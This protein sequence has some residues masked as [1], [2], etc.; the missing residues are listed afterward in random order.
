[1]ID[2]DD[3]PANP[4]AAPLIAGQREIIRLLN[5]LIDAQTRREDPAPGL[6]KIF[7]QAYVSNMRLRVKNIVLSCS[8]GNQVFRLLI[9]GAVK[10]RFRIPNNTSTWPF[11]VTVDRGQTVQFVDDATGLPVD[12]AVN[13]VL[14]AWLEAYVDFADSD[15]TKRGQLRDRIT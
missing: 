7:P 9:G 4:A 14:D 12:F 1:M 10:A 13:G 8:T 11:P 15:S 2:T 3:M 6:F 5:E